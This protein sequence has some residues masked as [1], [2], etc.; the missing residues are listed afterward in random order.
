MRL[1]F[2]F[3]LLIVKFRD[4]FCQVKNFNNIIEVKK[5]YIES[6]YFCN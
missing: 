5:G 4:V 3:D 6:T 1:V 2:I